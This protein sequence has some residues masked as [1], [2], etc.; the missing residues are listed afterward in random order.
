[1]QALVA[2]L[3]RGSDR[4]EVVSDY[5]REKRREALKEAI[6]E[7]HDP[8]EYFGDKFPQIVQEAGLDPNEL[9]LPGRRLVG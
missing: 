5:I 1:L 7:G 3:Y 2:D 6:A 9:G 8:A 4:T